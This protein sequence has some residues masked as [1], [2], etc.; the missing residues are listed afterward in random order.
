M[1]A[2]KKETEQR[3]AKRSQSEK[4]HAKAKRIKKSTSPPQK[5]ERGFYIVGMGA[6]AGGLE[7]FERFFRNTPEDSGMAFVLVS[8]LDPTH[9]SILPELLQKCSK[10]EVI[11]VQDGM[12]VQPNSVYVIPP[13]RD[14]AILHGTLHLIEP[15]ASHGFGLPIDYFLRSLAEDQGQRAICIILSGAG[16]DGTLG[17]RAI[18]G[19]MGMA[20]VQ[21]PNSAKY[22][23]MPNSAIETGLMDYILPPE[24]MPKQL[25]RYVQHAAL[26]ATPK[27]MP[28][29]GKIPD[30]VQKIFILLRTHTGHDFSLYKKSTIFRRIERRM[31]VHQIDNATNYVRYLQENSDEV[32]RL[33]KEL[34]IGVTNFFRDPEAFEALRQKVLPQ[35]LKD[36]PVDYSFRVWVAGCSSGEEAYSIAIILREYMD[37]LK[38]NFRIQVFGTDIDHDA[39]DTARAGIYPG[40]ISSDMNPDRLKRFFTTEDN[41]Y[42]IKQ[43][44]R[45]MLIFAP[46]D[47]IKHPPFTN[48]DLICCR[49]LLIYLD[50]ELQ[51]RLIPLL[52]YSLNPDGILF[53][54][55]SETIGGF[56][57]L[58]SVLDKKW[59]VYKR[60]ETASF[61]QEMLEFPTT[62]L[63]DESTEIQVT[64]E[65]KKT[66]ETSIPQLVQKILLES[67][68]P[69]CVIINEKAD[70]IYIHGRTGKYLEP[71]R[72]EASLNILEMA[73]EGLRLQLASAIH[74]AISQGKGVAHEGLPIKDNGGFRIINVTVKPVRAPEDMRGL[75]MV[76]FEDVASPKQAKL[77]KKS[78][79][80]KK[81][82]DK[83]VEEIERE[84]QYTKE[85][86][87]TTIEAL[88]TSNEELK[89]T[90]E[91]LQSTNEEL[92]SANE[93]LSTSKEELQSLNEELVTV[94]AEL[95]GKIDEVTNANNDMRNLMESTEI[96]TIF[97]DK[98]LCIKAFTAYAKKVINLIQTD[99]GRPIRH[100]VSNLKYQ[101]LVEDARGVL[102]SLAEKRTEVQ[103][104]DGH[105]YLMRI[106]PYRT[107]GNVIDGVVITFG[108]VHAQKMATD[109]E[110]R[111]YAESI[112]NTVHEPLVVLDADLKVISVNRSFFKAFQVKPEETEGKFIYELGNRQWDIPGLRELLEDILPKNT[113]FEGFEVEHDFPDI[114]YKKMLLNGR[115][116]F[117]E[118]VGTETILLAI[119]DITEH[120]KKGSSRAKMKDQE[121]C[122]AK[123]P[124]GMSHEKR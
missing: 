83:G 106:M 15:K 49:N 31:N 13:N 60:K 30:T 39:I 56:V 41:A 18:K 102:K 72:G 105:W 100:I 118:A 17:L 7:A 63:K 104:E 120:K 108:D 54:G 27:I 40:S 62:L 80:S 82:A 65:F 115:R 11:Q 66:G 111:K 59:K 97:L 6:S 84:L 46:Q 58:F 51:K 45:E 1:A 28:I 8:H 95:Q 70:I 92:R 16:T 109:Q 34:L 73:R 78:R 107:I 103:T 122:E 24:E 5:K 121:D 43:D 64:G 47:I 42:R 81:K 93:E 67:Y 50:T 48:L 33:F 94:N 68:A 114:G 87:Q 55:P 69:P 113:T 14:M 90:N 9:I 99:V 57:D 52:H 25:I 61:A 22:N 101:N 32:K 89:S 26:R 74:K 21:D 19:E 76:V 37:E 79:G 12:K 4:T 119:E 112:V 91:E 35:L 77:G 86:L 117:R 29:E 23:N 110:A 36:K 116:I 44:I 124:K 20:L 88:E 75:M 71:A 98:D 85:N 3:K 53:L 10:M 123:T 96:A 2:K 38:R